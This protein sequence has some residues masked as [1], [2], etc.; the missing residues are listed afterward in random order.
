MTLKSPQEIAWDCVK[1]IDTD[2]DANPIGLGEAQ[3]LII[4]AL[5]TERTRYSELTSLLEKVEE[6]L[7]FT[8]GREVFPQGVCKEDKETEAYTRVKETLLNISKFKGGE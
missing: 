4:Q 7:E 8:L 5:T 3:E 2:G 1:E 6:A